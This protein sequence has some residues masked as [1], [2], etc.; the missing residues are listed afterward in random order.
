MSGGRRIGTTKMSCI[1]ATTTTT[2]TTTTIT[3]IPDGR[4]KCHSSISRQLASVR[5]MQA[6]TRSHIAHNTRNALRC[7]GD[8]QNNT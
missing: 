8:T 7:V 3:T 4:T 5:P 6:A 2:T 1:V